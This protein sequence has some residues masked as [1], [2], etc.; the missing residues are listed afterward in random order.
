MNETQILLDEAAHIANRHPDE[1]PWH[2]AIVACNSGPKADFDAFIVGLLHDSVED[3]YATETELI[4]AGFNPMVRAAVN[5]LT[6]KDG[7][8]YRD[9]VERIADEPDDL[10]RLARRV[11]LA[12]AEVNLQRC[13][14]KDGY[15]GLE[16]RYRWVI[17]ELSSKT[18]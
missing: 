6:R 14:G 11:K 7:E 16:T 10:G 13:L 1:H 8:R 4:S 15:Q 2:V 12:D 18:G 17:E 3:G 9:Y 5:V